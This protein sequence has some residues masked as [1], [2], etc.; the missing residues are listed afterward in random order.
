[1]RYGRIKHAINAITPTLLGFELT[2]VGPIGP[3]LTLLALLNPASRTAQ[4]VA[5][6]LQWL[7]DSVGLGVK[8]LLNPQ[9]DLEK[10]PLS[11]YYR[12]VLPDKD[13]ESARV[14]T[15]CKSKLMRQG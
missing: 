7:R 11:S 3:S 15:F 1:M 14:H 12:Y 4:H 6:V 9:P 8:V 2:P 10:P 5:P 13:G